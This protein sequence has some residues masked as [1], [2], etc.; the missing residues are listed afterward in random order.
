MRAEPFDAER[1]R[2]AL[3]VLRKETDGIQASVHEYM[4]RR[5]GAMSADERRHLADAQWG[6]ERGPERGPEHHPEHPDRSVNGGR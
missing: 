2:Q 6:P 1:L 3:A 5:A 4:L